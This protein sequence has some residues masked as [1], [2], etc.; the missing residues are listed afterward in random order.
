MNKRE[1]E[2]I[3]TKALDRTEQRMMERPDLTP[4][5]SIQKQLEYLIKFNNDQ[6]DGSR[7]KD[8]N[9]GLVAVREI[10][11]WDNELADLL[12]EISVLICNEN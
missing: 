9:V 3:L 10:E 5:V 8:I 7:L 1:F 4:L 12:H 2:V 11:N 6:I